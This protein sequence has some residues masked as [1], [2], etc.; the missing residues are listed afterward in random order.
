MGDRV[1]QRLGNYRLVHLLGE[2][3]FAE[4]YLGEHVYLNTLAAVKVLHTQLEGKQ[5]ERFRYEA[6]TIAHMEHPN[7]V[8]VLE[9]GVEETTPFLIMSYAPNGT[10]RRRHPQGNQLQLATIVHYVRQ[11]AGALQYVHDQKLIHRDVKPQNMLL[12]PNNEVLLGDFGLALITESSR[13]QSIQDMAGTIAYMAPEQIQGKP[14]RASDQYALG[15]VVYEW[16]SGDLPFHG[17]FSEIG[18]QHILTLPPKLHEKIPAISPDV[19]EVVMATLAKDPQQRFASIRAFA[20]AFEQACQHRQPSPTVVLVNQ[21]PLLDVTAAPPSQPLEPSGLIDPDDLISQLVLPSVSDTPTNPTGEPPLPSASAIPLERSHVQPVQQ[22]QSPQTLFSAYPL[23]Q[24]PKN[25]DPA[26]MQGQTKPRF[27]LF[28]MSKS[29]P[30]KEPTNVLSIPETATLAP[31]TSKPSLITIVSAITVIVL[32]IIVTMAYYA[33]QTVTAT[34]VTINLSPQTHVIS[35]VYTVRADPLLQ[36][37]NPGAKSIPARAFNRT[38]YSSINGPT[39]G[40]VNC[41]A[42]VFGCQQGVSQEDVNNLVSQMQPELQQKITRALQQ[43]IANTRGMKVSLINFQ[44]ISIKS[45]RTRCGRD[46]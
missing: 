6:Q 21:F 31:R 11:I 33:Y 29:S 38:E 5:S 26:I 30:R 35:Q 18:S 41:I 12:G 1:G 23:N 20:T 16:L 28:D 37:P 17:S 42:G 4:V 7:I 13:R 44:I 15:V 10:L 43:K 14:R 39:T 46:N 27:S 34:A 8:R 32:L 40:L 45:T 36:T 2:G 25:T 3:G 22:N 9:F 24:P 19:E